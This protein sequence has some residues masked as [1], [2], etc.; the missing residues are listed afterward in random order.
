MFD[1]SW[2]NSDFLFP[3]VPVSLTEK[4]TSIIFSPGSK[5]NITFLVSLLF[6]TFLFV[7]L[8]LGGFCSCNFSLL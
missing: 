6:K 4:H 8:L 7:Y 5:Y 3:S 2:E 1:P